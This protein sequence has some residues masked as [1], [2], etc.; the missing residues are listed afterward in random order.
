[1]SDTTQNGSTSELASQVAGIVW[2]ARE[3]RASDIHWEPGPDRGVIRFRIDGCLRP[4]QTMPAPDVLALCRAA[5][6]MA[7]RD[8]EMVD[9]PQDGRLLL[10]REGRRLDV[11]VSSLPTIHGPRIVMRLLDPVALQQAF[12]LDRIVGDEAQRARLRELI[13]RPSGIVLSSGP[14]GSGKTT[15]VYAMLQEVS[16]P[17]VCVLTVEDPVEVAFQA[18]GQVQIRPARGLTFARAARSILR[19]DPDVIFV[20]ELRDPEMFQLSAQMALTGHLVIST[21]HANDAPEAV[22]RLIDVGLEPFLVNASLAGAISQRLVRRLCD[23]CKR[24][25]QPDLTQAPPQAAA[26]LGRGVQCFEAAGCE[27]CLHTGYRGRLGI[28]EVLVMGPQLRGAVAANAD[29]RDIKRAAIAEGMTTMLESGLH[30]VA[31]GETTLQEVLRVAPLN[32]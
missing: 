12:D 11:R 1:M 30:M 17:E 8:P 4:Q 20:G 27:H 16:R 6:E 23:Q 3:A 31:R 26:I 24:P 5:Q 19:Q 18:M 15:T 28:C 22:R 9:V 32:D 25:A 29:R 10:E 21:L 14:T 7:H 13:S 2:Q